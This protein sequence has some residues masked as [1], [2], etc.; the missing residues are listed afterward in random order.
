M[1]SKYTDDEL[2]QAVEDNIS[3]AGTLR[4]L[5]LTPAGGNYAHIKKKIARLEISVDHWKGQG[6]SNG[7]HVKEWKDYKKSESL[8]RVL[9]TDRGCSCE[10]CGMERWQNQ[11]IPIELHHIDGDRLNNKKDN[12]QLLCPNCHAMTKNWRGRNN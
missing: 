11:D 1:K 5:G 3:I 12:L 4:Q 6:W 10:S 9:L 7:K 2:R 8:K